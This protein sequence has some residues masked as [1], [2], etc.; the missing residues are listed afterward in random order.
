MMQNLP[1]QLTPQPQSPM[2]GMPPMGGQM[3]GY[4]QMQEEGEEPQKIVA[5]FAL[6]ELQDLDQL[7]LKTLQEIYKTNLPEDILF[8]PETG[9][10]NYT[11]LDTILKEPEIYEAFSSAFSQPQQKFAMGGGVN[12][13]GRP[14][15]PELEKLRLEGRHGDTELAIITPFL[16]ETFSKWAGR[17]PDINP[18]TGL[19][20]FIK[21]GNIFKTVARVGATIVGGFFGGPVGAALGAGLAT[22][23]TGG[24]WG[25]S[26]GAGAMGGLGAG[27]FGGIGGGASGGAGSGVGGFL[28]KIPGIGN[29][30]GSMG[31]GASGG[32]GGIL[33]NLPGIGSIF[34]GMGGGAPQ[35]IVGANTIGRMLPASA[36]GQNLGQAGIQAAGQA[37]GG[38]FLGNMLGGLGMGGGA[39]GGGGG[40]FLGNLMGGVGKA[41]PLVGSG[42]LMAKGHKDEQRGIREHQQALEAKEQRE[43][44]ENEAMRERMGFNAKLNPIEPYRRRQITPDI[45]PEQY[46]RGVAPS[47]FENYAEGGAIRGD[48]KG[49]QDNIPMDIED[50]SYIFDASTVS[51]IGDGSSNAGIKELD[52]YFSRIPS[53]QDE[54]DTQRY[55]AKGG[56]IQAMVSNDEYRLSPEK[57]TAIGGGSNKKGAQILKKFVEEIR[58][59]K[60][61]SGKRLPPKSKPIGGYLKSINRN[62]A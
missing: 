41:L 52:R 36:F 23:L 49:Q 37:G 22:K 62:A 38:G 47:Y 20:E 51:D 42:L 4:N 54:S 12:E 59:K 53:Q 26:L 43:K 48:G 3:D 19:P 2:Q 33:G 25:Q 11:P 60:R 31:G 29:L 15:D 44:A 58:E 27:I 56:Y 34:G 32:G 14:I 50:G 10:R 8:D 5:H 16:L 21:W 45:T 39:S 7:L 6:D 13:P 46:S 28:G 35:G 55:E 24:S 9:L 18:Q 57:V 1:H 17:E 61:T 40:G 30:F